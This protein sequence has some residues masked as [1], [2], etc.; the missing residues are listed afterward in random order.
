MFM[1]YSQESS[2]L[3]PYVIQNYLYEDLR[4]VTIV[5]FPSH[6]AEMFI[7]QRRKG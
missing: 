7:Y 1:V 3:E 4:Y 5:W 6:S 2:G